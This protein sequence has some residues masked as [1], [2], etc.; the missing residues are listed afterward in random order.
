[1][2]KQLQI[3]NF[4]LIEKLSLS[5]FPGLNILTG[6]TG[7]GKSIILDALDCALGGKVTSRVIRRGSDRA[8]VQA[9]FSLNPR[10]E[11]WLQAE[12]IPI[13]TADLVCS[14][15]ITVRSSRSKVNG[16][17]VNKQQMQSLRELLIEITAQG[18]TVL[19][20]EADRQREWLDNLGGEKLLQVKEQVKQLYYAWEKAHRTLQER[21]HRE[22]TRLQQIDMFQ[23]QLRELDEA[24]LDDPDELAKLEQERKRLSYVVDLQQQSYTVYQLLY[25]NDDYPA[26]VDLLGQAEQILSKMTTIDDSLVPIWEM[27]QSALTQV[28]EAGRQINA[29]GSSLETDPDRLDYVEKRLRQ[30]KQ[31]CRKYGPTL[32]DAIASAHKLRAYLHSLTEE[33]QPIEVLEEQLKLKA[34]KLQALAQTL[35]Q[36]RQESAKLLERE[37]IK[38]LQSLAM[39]K[40]QFEVQITAIPPTPSGCDQVQFLFS[41]NPGEPLQPLTEIASGGE[42]SRFLLAL[43]T[44]FAATSPVS[45]LV[46]DEIDVGVSGRVAQSIAHHLYRLSRRQQVLCVT[47][48][49]IVAAIADH[50]FHVAKHIVPETTEGGKTK[51]RTYVTVSYLEGESRKQELA[52]IAGGID[53]SDKPKRGRKKQ[54]ASESALAFAESLLEQADRLKLALG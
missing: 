53:V 14:R 51:E 42:M 48:Q 38:G 3:E 28:E 23:Y 22:Q 1:M 52:Q 18:Q 30:L 25:Q 50:H 47:H 43:K 26:C 20:A 10:V 4:A 5:L 12:N 54:T 46:F 6:E 33:E 31:I 39:E 32:T 36:L 8:L 11:N 17:I 41:P 45:T 37:M 24:N 27:V 40:V 15:E 44:C 19:L 49:P 34:E 7:A 35:T 21:K 16:I 29:Y 13:D 9:F 2:L